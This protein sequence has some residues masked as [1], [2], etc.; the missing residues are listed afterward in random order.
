MGVETFVDAPT[1]GKRRAKR[2]RVLLAAKLDTPAGEVECR[3]RDLSRK[4][5]LVECRLVPAV[6]SEV[7]FHRGATSVPARVAWAGSDRVGLEFAYMIDENEVL[8]QLKRTTSDQNQPRFR[9]PRLFGEDMSEQEKTIA[10][11]WAKSVGID[12]PGR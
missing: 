7:V 4:G 2:A 3:L 9:R 6:G 1:A 12:V 8:V 11:L 10:R 5:A